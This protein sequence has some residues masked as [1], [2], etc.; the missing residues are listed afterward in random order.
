MEKLIKNTYDGKNVYFMITLNFDIQN[1]I[2]FRSRG[3]FPKIRPWK[4]KTMVTVRLRS[5]ILTSVSC[6]STKSPSTQFPIKCKAH[7]FIHRL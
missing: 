5:N 3:I 4:K 6:D 2:D 1:L 7:T